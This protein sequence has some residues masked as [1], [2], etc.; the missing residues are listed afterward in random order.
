MKKLLF[1]TFILLTIN[2]LA[3]AQTE[4]I[5]RFVRKYKRSATG[6]KVDITVP[7]WL[8]RF[9]T[10]F[11]KEEDLEGVDIQ[12]IARKISEVRVVSIEGGSKIPHT[13]F[14]RLINDAKSENFEE[15]LNIR[16]DGDNVHI[17][18]R[19]KKG[20]IRDLFIMVQDN[21]GEFVLLDIGGKFTMEDINQAIQEVK[22][23]NKS[24]K[25]ERVTDL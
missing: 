3:Q 2:T 23:K 21:D 8:I 1:L 11:I 19:E 12:A 25:Q 22:I 4:S 18:M 14:M 13:D 17:L 9:G 15:L 16:S 10:K 24:S 5:D 7:G 6:E 20:F